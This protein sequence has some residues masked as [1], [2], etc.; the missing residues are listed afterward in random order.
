ML[1]FWEAAGCKILTLRITFQGG[2]QPNLVPVLL[3]Q[4]RLNVTPNFNIMDRFCFSFESCY[5]Y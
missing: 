3:E 1:I 2:V 4:L 5:Q